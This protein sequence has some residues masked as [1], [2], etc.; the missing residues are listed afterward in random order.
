MLERTKTCWDEFVIF[1]ACLG[2]VKG[3]KKRETTKESPEHSG[4][5]AKLLS[6]PRNVTIPSLFFFFPLF[7]CK[8]TTVRGTRVSRTRN[9]QPHIPLS[10][11]FFRC[12]SLTVDGQQRGNQLSR[13]KHFNRT[14]YL[15]KLDRSFFNS[16]SSCFSRKK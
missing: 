15:D 12:V 3:E 10:P 16:F 6:W 8:L 14:L 7:K 2:G 13:D 4:T 1:M 5:K 9:L 11:S